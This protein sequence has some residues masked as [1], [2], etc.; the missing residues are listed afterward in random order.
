MDSALDLGFIQ[1]KWYSIIMAIS[2]F[3]AY[4]IILKEAKKKGMSTDELTDMAFYGILIGIVGA[5]LYYVLFNLDY[6]INNIPEIIMIWHGGI[7]I[8]G[9]LISTLIFLIFYTKKKNINIKVLLDIIVVGLIIA[10]SIGRWGNF[11]NGEAFGREVSR[12]FLENMH[13]PSF[14]I[15]GMY[16]EKYSKYYE[17]TF[18]YESVL[19]LI[20]FIVLIILRKKNIKTGVLTSIYL[21]WY[22]ISRLIVETFRSDSLML[23]NIKTA[24]LVSIVGIIA[25]II[26][27]VKSVKKN[28]L[29]KED[30]LIFTNRRK[31]NV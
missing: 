3:L 22:G 19:S 21:V 5:R 18:L 30:E 20:G 25:G 9:A 10:Q 1:I 28:K 24:Q 8:H 13:L 11:F 31:Q 29:Y 17:P 6:Y 23:G 7:A 27:F 12:T 16:I 26:Y 15:D 2:I 14:I 4:L